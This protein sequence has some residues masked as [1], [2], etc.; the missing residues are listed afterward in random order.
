MDLLARFMPSSNVRGTKIEF[1]KFKLLVAER[2]NLL[3][4]FGS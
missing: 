4:I 1:F 3:E 2:I